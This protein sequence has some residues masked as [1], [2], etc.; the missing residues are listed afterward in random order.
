M[1]DF[2]ISF[3]GDLVAKRVSKYLNSFEP[4]NPK[5]KEAVYKI[6]V[7]LTDQ[8]KVNIRKKGL[9]DSERLLNSIVSRVK[10]EGRSITDIEIIS[11]KV[12]YARVLEEGYKGTL[13]VKQHRHLQVHFW[14]VPV[15]PFMV[16]VRAYN[17]KLKIKKRP[18]MRPA[19]KQSKTTIQNIFREL[20]ASGR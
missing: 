12:P 14:G 5:F 6:A 4:S 18:Y 19:F 7:A 10:T 16:D 11:K 17:R 9:I 15:N 2:Q 8:T 1:S 13:S 20:A 3:D